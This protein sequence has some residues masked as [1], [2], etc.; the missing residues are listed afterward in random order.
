MRDIEGIED[1]VKVLEPHWEEVMEHFKQQNERL[2]ELMAADHDAI[3]RVLKAHL[4]I[5]NFMNSFLAS[6][7]GIESFDD[8][9][10]SFFQKA[11]LLPS[12]RSSAAFVRPGIL[13]LNTVRNKF[14]HRANYKIED[15]EISGILTVLDIARKGTVF[16]NKVEAI[17]AF[18]SVACAFLIVPDSKLQKIFVQAFAKM[19]S[20]TPDQIEH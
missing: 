10:L 1:A 13:Q 6:N 7:Y 4:A 19:R 20:I 15:H 8:L 17:E 18:T 12:E 11:T 5:E 3:G 16:K 9:R 14:G 2:L